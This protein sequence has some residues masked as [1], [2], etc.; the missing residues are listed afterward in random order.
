[1]LIYLNDI[2]T[3]NCTKYLSKVNMIDFISNASN[4][5]IYCC[6][7]LYFTCLLTL[8]LYTSMFF[9]HTQGLFLALYNYIIVAI[10]YIG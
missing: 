5:N 4:V 6:I 10:V 9:L 8:H 2:L 7:W 3:V 1:M